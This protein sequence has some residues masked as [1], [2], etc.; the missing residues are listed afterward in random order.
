MEEKN[1]N[2]EII[3]SL[4][5]IELFKSDMTVIKAFGYYLSSRKEHLYNL[6]FYI[7]EAVNYKQKVYDLQMKYKL[8]LDICA[9]VNSLFLK[10]EELKRL[11]PISITFDDIFVFERKLGFDDVCGVNEDKSIEKFSI[12]NIDNKHIVLKITFGEKY[13]S[14]SPY[15]QQ[16]LHKIK[17]LDLTESTIESKRQLIRFI[18]HLE[19]MNTEKL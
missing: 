2:K 9:L 8:Y 1:R 19:K 10:R 7:D 17:I 5:K 12:H 13:D 11:L 4:L 6:G 16:I 3:E 14:D 18:Q 15:I